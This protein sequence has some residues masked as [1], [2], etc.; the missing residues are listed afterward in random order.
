MERPDAS[1]DALHAATPVVEV[2]T[3]RV[4]TASPREP[5]SAVVDRMMEQSLHQVPVVDSG[6][7]WVCSPGTIFLGFLARRP[8]RFHRERPSLKVRERWTSRGGYRGPRVARGGIEPIRQE[9]GCSDQS[10][11]RARTARST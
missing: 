10:A 9:T 3:R 8:C 1:L 11:P 4:V 5:L 2:M 7:W 6:A